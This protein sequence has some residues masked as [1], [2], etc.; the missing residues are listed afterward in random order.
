MTP[1]RILIADDHALVRAGFRGLL[2][3][4]EGVIVVAEAAD[5]QQAWDLI[6]TEQP[7]V[8]LLDISMP[9]LNGLDLTARIA[10]QNP[11]TKVIM[12]S[13]HASE[14]YIL[15]AVKVGAS[16]YLLKDATPEELSAAI[17][18]VVAG[19]TY[20]NAMTSPKLVQTIGRDESVREPLDMLTPRQ[21]EILQLIGEGYSTKEIANLLDISIKTAEAHRTQLM[22]RLG[23][24]DIA[25]VVRYAIRTGLVEP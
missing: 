24:H 8:A 15:R 13:M 21:R 20:F 18:T 25:S 4:I 16:G 1:I 3:G 14:D 19:G 17:K 9:G 7:T 12:L 10:S 23:L 22:N 11:Q 2:Q 6:R 5:G